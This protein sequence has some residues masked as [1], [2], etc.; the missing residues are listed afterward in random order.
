[1]GFLPIGKVLFPCSAATLSSSVLVPCLTDTFSDHG[2]AAT[3]TTA[4]PA[5]TERSRDAT[6]NWDTDLNAAAVEEAALGAERTANAHIFQL[7]FAP[8]RHPRLTVPLTSPQSS[9]T[10]TSTNGQTR[11][12]PPSLN[13]SEESHSSSAPAP[14]DSVAPPAEVTRTPAGVTAAFPMPIKPTQPHPAISI[15]NGYHI[16]NNYAPS[17]PNGNTTCLY[18]GAQQNGLTVTQIQLKGAF[19]NGRSEMPIA[20]NGS[21]HA[22]Y[23]GYVVSNGT[24]STSQCCANVGTNLTPTLVGSAL[25]NRSTKFASRSKCSIALRTC[26]PRGWPD[27]NP[28]ASPLLHH[29]Q[30]VSGTGMTYRGEAFT[31]FLYFLHLCIM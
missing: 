17:M 15:P 20:V 26:I 21:R 30:M 25:D 18:P 1:M 16:Q 3:P 5:A 10:P 4:G 13:G 24:N 7:Q 19:T 31:A 22:S 28:T 8:T 12:V 23:I 9:H 2:D 11:P 27:T 6:D 29:H 14:R